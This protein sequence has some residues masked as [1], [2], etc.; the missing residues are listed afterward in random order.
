MKKNIVITG[1]MLVLMIAGS[2]CRNRHER[3]EMSDFAMMH[4]M[5]KDE[6]LGPGRG[7]PD[8]GDRNGRGTRDGMM[9][10]M[11]PSMG[12]RMMGG[13][14]PGMEPGMMRGN[15][16][17][18]TD[19]T[20]FMPMNIGR[21]IMEN[22]PDV[23]DKQKKQVA[24]IMKKQHDEMR[25]IMEEEQTKMKNLMDSHRKEILNILTAEQKK[26]IES[27]MRKPAGPPKEPTN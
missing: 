13:M 22:I 27:D 1:V 19:S 6:D 14:G 10:G 11:G 25:K 16:P 4:R 15:G 7:M 8:M 26:F 24:D 12:N 23:T 3:K 5:G 17:M 20:G 9:E 18:P 21:M 2:G